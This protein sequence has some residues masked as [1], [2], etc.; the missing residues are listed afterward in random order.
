MSQKRLPY[1]RALINQRKQR[2]IFECNNSCSCPETCENRVTQKGS[3]CKV[4]IFK[5][6]DKGWGVKALE[7][8]EEGNRRLIL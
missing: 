1:K 8:I 2:P 5:T 3:S 6:T 7:R 4:M